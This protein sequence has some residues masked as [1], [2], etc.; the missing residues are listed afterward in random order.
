M[1]QNPRSSSHWKP[2][3][4]KHFTQEHKFLREVG[5]QWQIHAVFSIQVGPR[6]QKARF[7]MSESTVLSN[8]LG[9]PI[10][11]VERGRW[12]PFLMSS[13]LIISFTP[14]KPLG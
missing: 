13:G 9:K 7:Q 2:V 10:R 5:R 6:F 8:R 3:F 14:H 12:N 11:F 4:R 1:G